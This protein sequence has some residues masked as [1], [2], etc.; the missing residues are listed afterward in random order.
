MQVK[1]QALHYIYGYYFVELR[2]SQPNELRVQQ[3]NTTEVNK[4][5]K[6]LKL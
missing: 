2:E 3:Q 5:I 1:S 4:L 6:K